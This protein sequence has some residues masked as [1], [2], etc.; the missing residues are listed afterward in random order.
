MKRD[1]MHKC[2]A[3]DILTDPSL[4]DDWI[5]IVLRRTHAQLKWKP[6]M[7]TLL[8]Y[9]FRMSNKKNLK[10]ISKERSHLYKTVKPCRHATQDVLM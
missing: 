8:W 10:L 4:S 2:D 5:E 1:Y 9:Y 3:R 6:H 7:H